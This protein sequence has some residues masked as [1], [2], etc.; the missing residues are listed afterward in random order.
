PIFI[1]ITGHATI[2]YCLKSAKGIFLCEFHWR[3]IIVE[4]PFSCSPKGLQLIPFCQ[5]SI[6]L[7]SQQRWSRK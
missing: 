1:F 4:I 3:N 7:I 5:N 2:T 6:S